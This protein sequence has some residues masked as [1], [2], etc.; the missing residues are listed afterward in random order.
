M[1]HQLF[2]DCPFYDE[3]A[4]SF[5]WSVKQNTKMTPH[6]TQCVLSKMM[7]SQCSL[8]HVFEVVSKKRSDVQQE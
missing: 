6:S 2:I 7:P 4:Y 3:C 1:N 8:P 5:D